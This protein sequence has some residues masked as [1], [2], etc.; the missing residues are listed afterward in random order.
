MVPLPERF[1]PKPVT[2]D[3]APPPT[4]E[5]TPT[6]PDGEVTAIVPNVE[7]TEGSAATVTLSADEWADLITTPGARQRIAEVSPAKRGEVLDALLA[8][9][10]ARARQAAELAAKDARDRGIEEGR[11][12]LA[13]ELVV[14]NIDKM[15]SFERDELFRQNPG[16]EQLWHESKVKTAPANPV[17]QATNSFVQQIVDQGNAQ[18]LR[19]KDHPEYRPVY[20]EMVQGKYAADPSGLAQLAARVERALAT[21][22]IVRDDAEATAKNRAAALLKSGPKTVG[23]GMGGAAPAALTA[24]ALKQMTTEQVGEIIKTPQG[25]AMVM[26]LMASLAN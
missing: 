6:E 18:L 5:T 25:E 22:Q 7:G 21:N 9:S 3:E 11:N 16:A 14:Q 2:T 13:R 24:E 17:A 4:E 1:Q 19:L 26:K 12:A 20:D 15:E 10:E 8:K 23:V